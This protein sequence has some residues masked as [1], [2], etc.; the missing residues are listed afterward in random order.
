M[1]L[2]LWIIFILAGL[3][4]GTWFVVNFFEQ[5]FL[6]NLPVCPVC[7]TAPLLVRWGDYYS[8][9][10][11][12]CGIGT[13]VTLEKDDAAEEWAYNCKMIKVREG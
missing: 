6:L 13:D 2:I 10:C 12:C 1:M 3:I 11:P 8:V 9:D 7:G 4:F 5:A